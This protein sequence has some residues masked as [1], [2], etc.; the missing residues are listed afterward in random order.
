MR[1]G[2]DNF[3]DAK[4]TDVP[5]AVNHWMASETPWHLVGWTNTRSGGMCSIICAAPWWTS[6]GGVGEVQIFQIRYEPHST[7][8]A[9]LWKRGE[10][11][12]I[13]GPD[14]ANIVLF[15]E[16]VLVRSRR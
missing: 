12:G 1:V 14:L 6:G 3:W 7:F 8:L 9:R 16:L 13:L 11:S 2:T 15:E 10:G 4:Q 5:S